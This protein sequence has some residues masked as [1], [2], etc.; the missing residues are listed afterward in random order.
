[1]LKKTIEFVDYNGN[2]QK[3]DFYFNLNKAELTELE[4]SETGGLT[5]LIER[6]TKEENGAEIIRIF[7][8]LILLSYGKKSSDGKQF[9]KNEELSTAFSQT[10]AYV[11]LFMELASDADAASAFVNG[12]IPQMPAKQN[13]PPQI[14]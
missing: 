14:N 7:K 4:L 6:I 5:A 13:P 11:E 3:E 10:E 2:K 12:I 9:I 1:M 8:K